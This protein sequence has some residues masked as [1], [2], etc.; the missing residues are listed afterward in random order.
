MFTPIVAGLLFISGIGGVVVDE[1]AYTIYLIRHYAAKY[2][3][4]TDDAL[5]VSWCESRFNNVP[6]VNDWEDSYGPFQLGSEWWKERAHEHGR[7]ED[8]RMRKSIEANI[9]LALHSASVSGWG[10]WT[11]KPDSTTVI[12]QKKELRLFLRM[13]GERHISYAK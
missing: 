3:V 7:V 12:S 11:C 8:P 5:A 9:E 13:T 4:S 1:R 10:R 2:G 6:S